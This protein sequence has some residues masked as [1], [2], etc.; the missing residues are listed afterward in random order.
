MDDKS[1]GAFLRARRKLI[2]GLLTVAS[3]LATGQLIPQAQT[4]L[5]VQAMIGFLGAYGLHEV[6][7]D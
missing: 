2:V 3:I 5:I 7:N 4:E 6:A 1:I